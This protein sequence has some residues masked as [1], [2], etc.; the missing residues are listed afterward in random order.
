MTKIPEGAMCT[1]CG[2]AEHIPG[3]SLCR[4]CYNKHCR[5]L[6]N[7]RMKGTPLKQPAKLC[8][9]CHQHPV[10]G[11]RAV[12]AQCQR[13]N[14]AQ[15]RVQKALAKKLTT[16]SKKTTVPTKNTELCIRC[17]KNPKAPRRRI[18]AEC[19]K[20][21]IRANSKRYYHSHLE[22]ERARVK[23]KYHV[24]NPDARYKISAEEY[25]DLR[26]MLQYKESVLLKTSKE[27]DALK[28]SLEVANTNLVTKDT[29]IT[30]LEAKLEHADERLKISERKLMDSVKSEADHMDEIAVL[31]DQLNEFQAFPTAEVTVKEPIQVEVKQSKFK[32]YVLVILLVVIWAMTL[33]AG[34]IG[35]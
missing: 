2:K 20:A 21:E 14:K 30:E 26:T 17:G 16:A 12:C 29:L 34:G 27:R 9:Q 8:A 4:E 28:D 35:R 25:K 23:R 7:K 32:D 5:E 33:I 15:Y 1:K 22:Q 6:Y 10:T 13:E 19:I 24:A 31:K 11:T 18:C 3:R